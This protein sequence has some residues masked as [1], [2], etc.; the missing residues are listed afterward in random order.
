MSILA[1]YV[2]KQFSKFQITFLN[3]KKIIKALILKI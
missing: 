3:L 1:D 2:H